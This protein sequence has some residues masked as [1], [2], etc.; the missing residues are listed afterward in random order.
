MTN[1]QFA[2]KS[3]GLTYGILAVASG[4]LAVIVYHYWH[5]NYSNAKRIQL[6]SVRHASFLDGVKQHIMQPSGFMLLFGYLSCTWIFDFMPMSYYSLDAGISWTHV[7]LQL[8]VNDFLQTCMHLAEH[9]IFY[10]YH[11]QHHRFVCPSLFDAFHGSIMDTTL[12]ILGPLFCTAHLVHC[13]A[14]SYMAFGAIYSSWLTLI[15]SELSHPWEPA[16]RFLGLGTA[17]D[18]HV[19]HKVFKCNYGHLFMWWDRMI[20]TYRSPSEVGL[21]T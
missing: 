17:A 12:M 7:A 11:K 1:T 19:H 9:R 21:C 13:N 4:Q 2:D 10:F 15:H 3:L 16:F 5:L 8:I 14:W 6:F 18:H 20:G